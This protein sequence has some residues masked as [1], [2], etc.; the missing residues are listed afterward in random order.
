MR[1]LLVALVSLSACGPLTPIKPDA[2][3]SGGGTSGVGGGFT[4]GGGSATGGGL[5]GGS[6]TGGGL[7][8]GGGSTAGGS[9]AGGSAAG[10]SAAGGTAVGG[11]SAGGMG[12]GAP[13]PFTWV[14]MSI[15]PVP[16]STNVAVSARAGEAWLSVGSKLYRSTGGAFN[17]L[18][19][20]SLNAS[21]KDVLVTP[22]GK[23]FV[24][25]GSSS[26]MYCT[27]AD[28]TVATNYLP[29][30]SGATNDYFDG[31]CN[32]GESVYAIGNGSSNQ[33]ILFEF[34]GIGWTK[35][36]NDLGFQSPKRCVAGPSGEVY[37]L[38]KTFVVRY[39]GGGFGQENVN[40][41]GQSPAE[42]NDMAFTF[43]PGA[44]VDAMLVGGI[45]SGGSV[46]SYRYARRD[47]AGGG[48][49][50]LPIPMVGSSLNAV[51][52]VGPNEYL[53]AGSPGGVPANRFMSWNGTTWVA[54]TN[55][56]PTAL[57]TVSDAAISTDREVFL[58]GTGGSGLVVIRGRR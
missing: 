12:G 23:V 13:G 2:G 14:S 1:A 43:G 48:W 26:S 25:S 3:S 45:G 7:A 55:Q 58:A 47:T 46:T 53:A 40:L 18:P 32:N 37:V 38:G 8:T 5:A 31:L 42:W 11:G 50:A 19:A 10:G 56:P 54:A 39:E 4:F 29:A 17:E 33:A 15:V 27:S 9:A 16:S 51:I 24:I 20:F 52:A 28:C 44:A 57:V 22:G 34:N 49:T 30:P 41:M 36:S 35:V 21:A 6:G